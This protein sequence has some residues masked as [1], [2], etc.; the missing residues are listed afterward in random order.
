MQMITCNTT[1]FSYLIREWFFLLWASAPVSDRRV[2][3]T[4]TIPNFI[5]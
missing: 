2:V 5:E 4:G 1:Y 3:E